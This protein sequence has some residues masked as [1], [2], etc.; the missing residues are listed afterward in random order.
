MQKY[1]LLILLFFN[2]ALHGQDAG[3]I[4]SFEEEVIH[5]GKVTKGDKVSNEFV[6]TNISE[7]EIEI[8]MVSTCECT[9]AKWTLGKIKPGEKGSIQFIFDSNEKDKVE[10]IDV[11]VYFFDINPDTGNPYSIYLQYTFEFQQ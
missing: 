1:A 7:G 2:L 9:S 5:L 4:A 11:D 6:F 8:D 3:T 10:P